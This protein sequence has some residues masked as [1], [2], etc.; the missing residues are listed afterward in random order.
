MKTEFMRP[1]EASIAI[2]I[3]EIQGER[4]LITRPYHR[5]SDVEL[6]RADTYVE[7]TVDIKRLIYLQTFTYVLLTSIKMNHK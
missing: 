1:S 4:L 6:E 2:S 7:L 3:V 5:K